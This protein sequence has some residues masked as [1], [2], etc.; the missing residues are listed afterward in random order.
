MSEVE[1]VEGFALSGAEVKGAKS[2]NFVI[3]GT[4]EYDTFQDGDQAKRRLKMQIDFSG[5]IVDYYPNKT[6]QAKIIAEKGRLLSAW[7]GYKGEFEIKVQR[8]G[9]EDK[10]VIYIK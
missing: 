8:V 9:K 3:V 1:Y 5:A 4:P 10:E 7:V 6:S 2:K